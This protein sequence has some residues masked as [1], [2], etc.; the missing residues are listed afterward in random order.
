M[1]GHPDRHN[2]IINNMDDI[3]ITA[4]L[5]TIRTYYYTYIIDCTGAWLISDI[6]SQTAILITTG[7]K[8]EH[9]ALVKPGNETKRLSQIGKYWM[10]AKMKKA[11]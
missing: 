4:K 11:K 8:Y 2:F 5:S 7:K 6:K 1:S 10:Y 9:V 3:D